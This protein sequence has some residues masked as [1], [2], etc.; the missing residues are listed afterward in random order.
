M[1][2]L[3]SEAKLRLEELQSLINIKANSTSPNEMNST[4]GD[5]MYRVP[6]SSGD[7]LVITPEIKSKLAKLM[8]ELKRIR[9]NARKLQAVADPPLEELLSVENDARKLADDALKLHNH[10]TGL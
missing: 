8:D 1:S 3:V 5:P 4:K 7:R 10:V 9:R 6:G 2:K